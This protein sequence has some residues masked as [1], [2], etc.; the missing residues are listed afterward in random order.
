MESYLPSLLVEGLYHADGQIDDEVYVYG[1]FLQSKMYK[2]GVTCSDCHD[3][4]SLALKAPGNGVC[5]QCHA[6][7]KYETEKHRFHTPGS[8]G[9][10]CVDCHMPAKTYMVIDPRR[11]HSFRIPRLDLSVQLGTPNACNRCHRDKPAT[12]AAAKVREWYGHEPAGYQRYAEA[13]QAA[14]SGALDAEVPLLAL[15]RDRDQ[16]AIASA[17]AGRAHRCA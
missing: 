11:D 15:L 13:L 5:H 3:P 9:A 8:S 1:S 6:V 16:P 14:R 2:V 10:N 17:D 12:W 4:H 7:E